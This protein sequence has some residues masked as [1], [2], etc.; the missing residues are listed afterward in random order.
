MEHNTK[1]NE[2]Y[3][4]F[5]HIF[6]FA[7]ST[8]SSVQS[9]SSVGVRVGVSDSVLGP[10]RN[11]ASAE[12]SALAVRCTDVSYAG[13]LKVDLGLSMALRSSE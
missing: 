6:F 5:L 8:S 4:A 12:C 11:E 3:F 1:S 7:F 13:K 2:L 10:G 9:G